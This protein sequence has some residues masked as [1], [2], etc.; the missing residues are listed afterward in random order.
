MSISVIKFFI[1]ILSHLHVKYQG[2]NSSEI[3]T[4]SVKSAVESFQYLIIGE[5]KY[6]MLPFLDNLKSRSHGFIA[7]C[8][9]FASLLHNFS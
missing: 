8:P 4:F 6:L 7:S 9:S 2:S 5:F 1:I 3:E